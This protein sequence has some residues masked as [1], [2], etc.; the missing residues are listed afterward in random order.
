MTVYR[1]FW[2]EFSSWY[3]ELVKPE[4]GKPIDEKTFKATLAYF[5]KMLKI[6]HP[7]MPFI[8]EE[9]WHQI[10]SR[11]EGE[12][13]MIATWPKAEPV[14][15]TKLKAV[16]FSKEVI[17]NIR[18]IRKEKNISFKN[19]LNLL[20]GEQNDTAMVVNAIVKKL[21]N[22]SSIEIVGEH[23]VNAASFRVLSDEFFVP[24]SESAMDTELELKKLKEEL[25]YNHGFLQ[26]VMRKLSNEKFVSGAPEHVVKIERQ[27]Q[28]D[29]E[30]KIQMLEQQIAQLEKM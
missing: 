6:L 10:V 18:T 19:E 23:P 12:S 15:E 20:M 29:T 22:I 28:A 13:L 21:V 9:I 4:Y 5:E 27:K 30:T 14:D 2:D 7:F 1:L 3:L 26:S 11:G 16:E 25:T 8:S 17:V 24:L